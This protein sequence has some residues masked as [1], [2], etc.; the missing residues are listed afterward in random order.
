M[1]TSEFKVAALEAELETGVREPTMEKAQSGVLK[2]MIRMTIGFLV[3]ILGI[4]MLPLPGPGTIVIALGL[5]ILS[6]DV[7]W[8]D[9]LLN[10]LRAKTPGVP[11]EGEAWPKLTIALSILV[12]LLFT[13]VSVVT[14]TSQL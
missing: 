14:L 7:R 12:A 1:D 13:A 6:R 5:L 4:I 10:K 3:F 8:A 2:R 9:R 11:A